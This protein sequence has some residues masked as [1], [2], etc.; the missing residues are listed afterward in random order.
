M[1]QEKIPIIPEFSSYLPRTVMAQHFLGSQTQLAE[2]KLFI[3]KVDKGNIPG[4]Y[5]TKVIC[6]L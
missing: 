2:E 1:E 3:R 6:S 4:T 5:R